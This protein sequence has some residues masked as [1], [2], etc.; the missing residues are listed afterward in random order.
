MRVVVFILLSHW[1]GKAFPFGEAGV[2]GDDGGRQ[3][4]LVPTPFV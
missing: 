4:H 3:R 2:V 1:E